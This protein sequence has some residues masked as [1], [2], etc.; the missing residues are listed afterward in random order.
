VLA[1]GFGEYVLPTL[2]TLYVNRAALRQPGRPP[3][4]SEDEW[5]RTQ[6]HNLLASSEDRLRS[7]EAK[8]PG[9]AAACAVVAAGVLLALSQ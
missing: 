2:S 7:I 3:I 8:G 9:L 1:S 6:R 5:S 4:L